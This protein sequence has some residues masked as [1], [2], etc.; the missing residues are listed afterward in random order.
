MHHR[1]K[2][3][4]CLPTTPSSANG[5]PIACATPPT[6][7]PAVNCFPTAP[8]ASIILG[9]VAIALSFSS[10]CPWPGVAGV[11]ILEAMPP[12]VRGPTWE[13][14]GWSREEGFILGVWGFGVC[15]VV[16]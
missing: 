6:A 7:P 1:S 10:V 4:T 13:R 9:C 8:C 11:L 16:V 2:Q 5:P 12:V 15:V 3:H 14:G